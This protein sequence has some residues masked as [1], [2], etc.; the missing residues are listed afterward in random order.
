M[1]GHMN[2]ANMLGMGAHMWTTKTHEYLSRLS[3]HYYRDI[4]VQY[5]SIE[6]FRL[7]IFAALLG[8]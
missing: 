3:A 2:Y 7:V 8:I 4:H 1:F 5:A 6:S